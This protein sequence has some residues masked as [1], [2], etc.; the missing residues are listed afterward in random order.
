M[1][2]VDVNPDVPSP[3]CVIVG[4]D[5][6]LEVVN[7]TDRFQQDGSPTTVTWADYPAR[8][9]AVEQRT[10][11]DML[12]GRYLAPGVHYLHIARYGGSSAEIWLQ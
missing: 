2:E 12:F 10:T 11:F 5:Q 3:R 4:S 8:S 7:T 9:L 1:V 6:R